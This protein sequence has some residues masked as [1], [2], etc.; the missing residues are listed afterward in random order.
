MMRIS[1]K[2]EKK[3][4]L[5]DIFFKKGAF[6]PLSL[7]SPFRSFHNMILMSFMLLSIIIILFL[8]SVLYLQFSARLKEERET[9]AEQ[10]LKQGGNRLEEYLISMR[11]I[12]DAMYYDVIKGSNLNLLKVNTEMNLLYE[13]HK[14]SLVSVAIFSGGG[15]LLTAVPN[16]TEK[17]NRKVVEQD[18][19]TSAV[20]QVENLHF[21]LP[22]VQNLFDDPS[23]RTHWVV[24]LSRVVELSENGA[25]SNG[26]LLVDMNFNTIERM[27]EK[28][29]GEDQYRY[30]YLC[31]KKGN[32]IYHPRMREILRN[33][34]Q[35]NTE[36]LS[37]LDDGIHHIKAGSNSRA[38][39]VDTIGYTGWKMVAVLEEGNRIFASGGMLYYVFI[40]ISLTLLISLLFNQLV[41]LRLSYPIRKLN[42]DLEKMGERRLSMEDIAHYG[43][44]E[45]IHLGKTLVQSFRQ[46]D[47]LTE[48]KIE[49][50]E[51][52]RQ[53]EMDALQSQINPHFLYNTLE[54]VVW[55]IESGKKDDAVFMVTE[56]GSFFRISLSGGKNIIP[57]SQELQHAKNYMNI[58]QIRFKD[59]FK[60]D[61]TVSEEV[62]RCLTVKLILQPILENAI[63]HGMAGVDEDGEIH[64]RGEMIKGENSSMVL[65][66]VEDNGFGMTEEKAESLLDTEAEISDFSDRKKRGSGVGLINV[67]RRIQLRFGTRFGLRIHSE[68][69]EG[70]RVEVRLPAIEYTEETQKSLEHGN[71]HSSTDGFHGGGKDNEGKSDIHGGGGSHSDDSSAALS[72]KIPGGE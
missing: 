55:M 46:I 17:K 10:L 40:L 11:Q 6:L 60:V 19:F 35:E 48:E 12:S 1:E 33:D 29:N 24:S 39:I 18:F 68:P 49:Q 54:S 14:E 25:S 34:F 21:S 38:I 53:T 58:Q 44:T 5:Q 42:E 67:H 65:L 45:I 2:E 70:T 4:F 50:Q 8:S 13:A 64:V 7:R 27:M 59:K 57:L 66:S 23:F 26:V 72:G 52:K 47:R 69:D 22:H 62:L 43:S 51:E 30:F 61:F 37:E 15:K 16:S 32:L 20:Q 28:L 31:D 36:V 3:H 63:Y 56:L 41:S 71:M 9:Q